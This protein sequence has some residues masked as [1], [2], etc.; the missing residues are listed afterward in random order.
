MSLQ[1]FPQEKPPEDD[2][3]TKSG[4][5]SR[6]HIPFTP[7]LLGEGGKEYARLSIIYLY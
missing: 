2:P 4:S 5:N 6:S 1:P 7:A 3:L